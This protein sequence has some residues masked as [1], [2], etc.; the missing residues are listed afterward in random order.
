MKFG[1]ARSKLRKQPFFAEVFKIQGVIAL[2]PFRR[3]WLYLDFAL[4]GHVFV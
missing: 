2:P 3:P 4:Q 1:F